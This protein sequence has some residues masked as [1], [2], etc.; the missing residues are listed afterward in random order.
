MEWLWTW[1]G[2]SFGY[3]DGDA[4]WTHDGRHVGQFYGDDVYGTDG[5]YLGELKNR[6]RLIT[7]LGKKGWRQSPFWP[8][9]N[10][11]AY[12]PYTDYVGYVMYIG[13]EDFPPPGRV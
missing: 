7:N 5:R 9:G 11:V 6:N 10:R 3:R 12:V 2:K 13:Y 8:Y 4:L 1:G